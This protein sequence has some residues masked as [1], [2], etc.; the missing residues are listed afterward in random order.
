[1]ARLRS[2]LL[3]ISPSVHFPK[4]KDQSF[5]E[6]RLG[7]TKTQP[8][9]IWSGS[10]NFEW[11]G[12]NILSSPPAKHL[13]ITFLSRD[14]CSWENE[15]KKCLRKFD[16]TVSSSCWFFVKS[17]FVL[18]ISSLWFWNLHTAACCWHIASLFFQ[19]IPIVQWQLCFNA[20]KIFIKLC[21][22]SPIAFPAL[23]CLLT[24]IL[25]IY[26]PV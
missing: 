23:H 17:L 20:S 18:G 24:E 12:I 10:G 19:V 7:Q 9:W 26:D 3:P 4:P 2:S 5:Y 21:T 16:F 22:V 13:A 15:V 11:V 8:W 6:L 25:V 14:C 1:M